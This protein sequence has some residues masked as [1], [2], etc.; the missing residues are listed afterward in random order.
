[1]NA[2]SAD[3]G[4]DQIFNRV[5]SG[6]RRAFHVIVS[7]YRPRLLRFTQRSFGDPGLADDLVQETFIAIYAARGTYDPRFAFSTWIWTV[8]FN[9]CRRERRRRMSLARTMAGAIDLFRSRVT[10]APSPS[11]ELEQRER[12]AELRELLDRLPAAQADAIRLR[13]FAEL[14]FDQVAA[15][16][17]SSVSGAKVR[18]RK[19]L[20]A[21]SG[22]ISRSE[23]LDLLEAM[24]PESGEGRTT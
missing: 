23:S 11:E 18:V 5:A 15:A 3:S 14:P 4:D 12:A 17:N 6:D 13:F 10:A 21:L 8:H 16:M 19:G 24:L 22:W 9:V 2:E 20:Q 1:M 7:R